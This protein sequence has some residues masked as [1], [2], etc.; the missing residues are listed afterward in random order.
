VLAYY[1]ATATP[2][3]GFLCAV[4]GPGTATRRY[5][6]QFGKRAPE[7]FDGFLDLTAQ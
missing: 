1:Y 3:D 4:S 2:A 5:A 6:S 7:V